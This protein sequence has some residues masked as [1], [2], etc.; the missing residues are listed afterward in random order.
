MTSRLV[1]A[2]PFVLTPR[3]PPFSASPPR[4]AEDASA[5][6][7]SSVEGA[8]GVEHLNRKV[9][10]SW[11]SGYCHEPFIG[12]HGRTCG[13]DSSGLG[14]ADLALALGANLVDL[15]AAFPD[16]LRPRIRYKSAR[17]RNR[18]TRANKGVRDKDLLS[19]RSGCR[20]R[21]SG[22]VGT[23]SGG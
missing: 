3:L 4:G 20:N 5:M 6:A 2:I 15:H 12:V 22:I 9:D 14:D 19:L 21:G 17:I 18:P 23:R 13:S 10:R 11:L 8:H 16:D 7:A 1:N